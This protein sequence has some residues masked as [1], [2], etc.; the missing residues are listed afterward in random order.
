MSNKNNSIPWYW[1]A[2]IALVWV[3]VFFAFI[4]FSFSRIEKEEE[5]DPG[6]VYLEDP[7]NF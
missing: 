4:W 5:P 1:S 2:W 7:V 3:A 6:F